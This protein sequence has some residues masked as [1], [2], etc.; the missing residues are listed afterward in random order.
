MSELGRDAVPC[1]KPPR[2]KARLEQL[3][4]QWQ[5]DSGQPVARLN[6]RIAGDPYRDFSFRRGAVSE[7]PA[8]PNVKKVRV[9]VMFAGRV[10]S[11]PHLEIAP[12]DT[13][14]EEFVAI[15]GQPGDAVWL[16]G[17]D[18]VL[19]LAER[20]QISHRAVP[21]RTREPE[22]T[23]SPGRRRA[24]ALSRARRPPKGG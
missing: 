1:P 4:A 13:G 10:L 15:P 21:R 12:L 22:A 6:L 5:K 11:S 9:Q 3:I 17:P 14:E 2:T 24:A 8:R 18:E 7:L 19:V 23:P 16:S 20:W